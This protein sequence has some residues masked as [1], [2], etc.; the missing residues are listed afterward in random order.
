MDGFGATR[1][2]QVGGFYRMG[3]LNRYIQRNINFEGREYQ[4]SK[5]E[6]DSIWSS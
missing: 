5:Y 3:L 6:N 4:L 2:I 1:G